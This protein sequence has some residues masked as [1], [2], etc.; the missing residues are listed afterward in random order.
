MKVCLNFIFH[1]DAR[2]ADLLELSGLIHHKTLAT[3]V[4]KYTVVADVIRACIAV[5]AIG[6]VPS[7]FKL[8]KATI[9]AVPGLKVE[10]ITQRL[11]EKYPLLK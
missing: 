1:G 11:R 9:A 2:T 5:P 3:R 8:S 6:S 4:L 7:D 10:Y